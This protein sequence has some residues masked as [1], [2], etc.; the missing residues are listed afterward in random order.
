[1]KEIPGASL[2]L[3]PVKVPMFQA[4]AWMYCNPIGLIECL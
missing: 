2:G 1:M 3:N 4:N